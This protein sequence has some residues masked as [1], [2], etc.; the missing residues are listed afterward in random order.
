MTMAITSINDDGSEESAE[1]G[2]KIL[3]TEGVGK[4]FGD[5]TALENINIEIESG[6]IHSVIG[7]NG[8]GKTTLFNVITGKYEPTSGRIFYAGSDVTS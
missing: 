5:F 4:N 7:P 1:S 6:R 8:A 3:E 2:K